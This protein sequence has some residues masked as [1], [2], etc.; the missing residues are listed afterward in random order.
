MYKNVILLCMIVLA[1]LAC[2]HEQYSASMKASD[3]T[4]NVI[5]VGII[6]GSESPFKQALIDSLKAN[7]KPTYTVKMVSV[8][9]PSDLNQESYRVVI[10]MD[11]LKANL[12]M[13]GKMKTLQKQLY[14]KNSL[15]F[16]TSG[17]KKWKW[18]TSDIHHLASASITS[19]MPNTW[20]RLKS[21][22]DQ[23]LIN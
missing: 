1:L 18:K 14:P 11:Q 9:Q 22:L 6:K 3:S 10:V 13:N 8:D 19:F 12:M 4:S 15:F 16:I 20:T 23:M 7:Y 2:S 21:D 5:L 17:D